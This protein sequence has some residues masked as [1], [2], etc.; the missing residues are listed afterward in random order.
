LPPYCRSIEPDII[1]KAIVVPKKIKCQK[2]LL[3]VVLRN[4]SLCSLHRGYP[5]GYTFPAII[6]LSEGNP[7]ITVISRPYPRRD[8]IYLTRYIEKKF[9]Y[10]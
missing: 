4:A 8:T 6:S 3:W 5:T 7:S 10:L 2:P 1:T 9:F